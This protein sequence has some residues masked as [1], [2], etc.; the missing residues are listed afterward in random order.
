[1]SIGPTNCGKTFLFRPLQ[2][3]FNCFSNPSNDKY[4]WV[5]VEKA[6][7]IFLNDFRFNPELILWKEFLLLLEGQLVHLSAPKNHF[8]K[9]I[10]LESDVPVFATGKDKI[11]LIDRYN[12]VDDRETAMMDSRWHYV[13]MTHIKFQK[14]KQ[15]DIEPCCACFSKLVLLGEVEA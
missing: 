6:E 12:S 13:E 15:K 5:G 8:A 7:C 4:A 1:M 9:D 14:E 10:S 2:S 3:L 11:K